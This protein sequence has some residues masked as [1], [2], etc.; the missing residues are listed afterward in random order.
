MPWIHWILKLLLTEEMPYAFPLP[1]SAQGTK[2]FQI[3][4]PKMTKS[5]KWKQ[6]I[7]KSIKCSMQIL[8]DWRN[9][10]WSICKISSMNMRKCKMLHND[11]I[12]TMVFMLVNS[13]FLC[14]PSCVIT[15]SL[16]AHYI[17][18]NKPLSL[19]LSWHCIVF[20]DNIKCIFTIDIY[21]LHSNFEIQTFILNLFGI[22]LHLQ[23]GQIECTIF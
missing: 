14:V 9:P 15:V 23:I 6:E 1:W 20:H 3:C 19:S 21:L 13:E 2:K 18:D 5:I 10:Q 22:N 16:C 4:F 17:T 12:F 11:G 8:K 7:L